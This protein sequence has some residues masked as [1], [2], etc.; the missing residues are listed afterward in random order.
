MA[1][2]ADWEQQDQQGQQEQMGHDGADQSAEGGVGRVV[3]QSKR[4]REDLESLMSSLFEARGDW[5]AQLRD[6]LKERPYVGLAAA[7]GIGYVLGA[8]ISPRLIRT[9]FGLGSRGAFAVMM[10]RLATPLTDMVAGRAA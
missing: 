9:V 6:R 1:A 5:E 4:V 7:A 3:E 10:R 8:G 2:G